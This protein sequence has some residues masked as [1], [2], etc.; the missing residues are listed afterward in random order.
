MLLGFLIIASGVPGFAAA[1][2]FRAV[3]DK[4]KLYRSTHF[5]IYSQ[6]G[7]RETR[8]VLRRLEVVRAV[9]L[10][11]FPIREREP[12]EVTIYYFS[13]RKDF[14]SYLP[15]DSA[16]NTVGFFM[17][18]P[19]RDIMILSGATDLDVALQVVQMHYVMH[20]FRLNGSK[21]PP[22]L[23]TAAGFFSRR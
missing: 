4:W 3:N 11:T 1:E 9:F 21:A 16:N 17:P 7:E 10:Q 8:D 22:W 5:E 12:S 15:T 19:D 20:L 13:G 14:L 2:D 23:S 6:R 18:Y